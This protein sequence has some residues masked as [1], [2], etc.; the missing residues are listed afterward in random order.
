MI[1]DKVVPRFHVVNKV[2]SF[3]YRKGWV[4]VG[5]DTHTHLILPVCERPMLPSGVVTR[6]ASAS[7]LWVTEDFQ[8]AEEKKE[9]QMVES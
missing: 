3:M 7:A 4:V 1:G 5:A 8:R 6:G 2:K 9:W